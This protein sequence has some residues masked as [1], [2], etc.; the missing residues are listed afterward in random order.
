MAVP[1]PDPRREPRHESPDLAYL[2]RRE[3]ATEPLAHEPLAHG[4]LSALYA[5]PWLGIVH[6]D[7][8]GRVHDANRAVQELCGLP[9]A[10]LRGRPFNDLVVEAD[11]PAA[12]AKLEAVLGGE[13]RHGRV[14]LR[15]RGGREHGIWCHLTVSVVETSG[16]PRSALV[17]LQD[18]SQWKEAEE[19][20]RL[21]KLDLEGTVA[22]LQQ[23]T[24]D[25]SLLSRLG[26]DL[27]TCRSSDE[28]H[29]VIRDVAM[30]LFPGEAGMV[31]MTGARGQLLETV[32][33]WGELGGERIFGLDACLA[34]RKGRMHLVGDGNQGLV[35]RHV[36]DAQAGSY[37]CVPMLAH[38][39][40]LGVLTLTTTRRDRPIDVVVQL[41]TAVAEHI[42]LAL[43]NIK[44]RDTLR[45]QSIRDPLTG[46]FN[47][48]YMEE[49]LEREVRRAQRSRHPVGVIMLDL[50]HFK[51]LNDAH[52][53]DAGDEVLRAV[54]A[55]LQRS[56]RA[57]DIAC[58]YG[59]E[60]F[61]LILPEASLVDASHRAEYLR[62]AVKV[63]TIDH[64]D[65]H[66]PPASLSAGV[67]IYPD[68]G[69]SPTAVLRAADE[70][71]YRAKQL[72]RDRVA[73]NHAGG[74]FSDSIVDFTAGAVTR[75]R[76]R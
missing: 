63:L 41:A 35:C 43:A 30:R 69:P 28:A 14:E 10:D 59:G 26:E 45:S 11:A 65:H 64:P 37:L 74:L 40:L 57:E 29:V 21:A 61:T 58:R 53:H 5:S 18:I 70:A 52:G 7:A 49:S 27:Q 38:G 54:G 66:L 48:R 33:A 20:S 60:E 67:A 3:E 68:H 8:R 55:L 50:D 36:H 22:R 13:R 44:L 71:L 6:L 75:Q 76:D 39:E 62:Q 1:I 56:V 73:T 51:T 19:E 25:I 15:L 16:A 17:I 12:A 24:R 31:S 2:A 42:A 4:L 47:R 32:V 46:L 72:G 9:A 34:L 23:Q